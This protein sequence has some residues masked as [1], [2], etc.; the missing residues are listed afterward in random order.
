MDTQANV[1]RNF[2]FRYLQ[3]PKNNQFF[4]PFFFFLTIMVVI[5]SEDISKLLMFNYNWPYQR[6]NM[7]V[8]WRHCNSL[9]KSKDKRPRKKKK[10]K[11]ISC[12]CLTF[13]LKSF[14]FLFIFIFVWVVCEDLDIRVRASQLLFS[15]TR[16]GFPN[17]K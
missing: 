10:K 6:T 15:P 16:H 4:L 14:F 17:F 13:L 5:R 3:K 9:L 8:H 7:R 1:T 12:N 2:F 11:A